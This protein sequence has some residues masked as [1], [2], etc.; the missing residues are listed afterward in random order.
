MSKVKT[1]TEKIR[2]YYCAEGND[3]EWLVEK[4]KVKEGRLLKEACLEIERLENDLGDMSV[5]Y[6]ECNYKI[7]RDN[8][9]LIEPYRTKFQESNRKVN[10]AESYIKSINF[11]SRDIVNSINSLNEIFD[12]KK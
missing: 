6:S 1:V 12:F 10:E 7:I 2:E 11:K 9:K 4:G 5:K 3:N 8:D